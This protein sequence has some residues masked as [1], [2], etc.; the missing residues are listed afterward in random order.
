MDLPGFNAYPPPPRLALPPH[1]A[2]GFESHGRLNK[3]G[4]KKGPKP[5]RPSSTS[6]AQLGSPRSD[7]GRAGTRHLRRQSRGCGREAAA[8]CAASGHRPAAAV[9][10][11]G[12][13]FQDARSAT[14]RGAGGA[15][16]PGGGRRRWVLPPRPGRR[17]D[18]GRPGRGRQRWRR[19]G[20]GGQWGL[21]QGRGGEEEVGGS[22]RVAA[23]RIRG[24]H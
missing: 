10:F 21:A 9:D 18:G 14:V 15:G 23:A 22:T 1:T 13:W 19:G 7:G 20:Q 4:R 24:L 16:G 8:G 11:K 12:L 17:R 2:P 5:R 6:A 3:R